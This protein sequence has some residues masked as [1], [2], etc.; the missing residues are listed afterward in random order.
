MK[1]FSPVLL[2]G[3]VCLPVYT[4]AEDATPK[5]PLTGQ[6][7]FGLEKTDG[8]TESETLNA[9]LQLIYDKDRWTHSFDGSYT[10]MQFF[11]EDNANSHML[12]E[13]TQYHLTRE[14]NYAFF[15]VWYLKD[16]FSGYDGQGSASVGYGHKLIS[17][18]KQQLTAEIGAGLAWYRERTDAANEET[19]PVGI[20]NLEYSLQLTAN[21]TLTDSLEIESGTKNT[22]V[23]NVLS[24][25]VAMN[26]KWSVNLSYN[27]MHNTDALA[28]SE[29]TDTTFS[30]SLAYNF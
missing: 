15:S 21:T 25:S 22:Y 16:K 24:L 17:S 3:L 30:T 29:K 9:A 23:A 5:S 2:A 14:V 11:G 27:V 8:N 28:G 19:Y 18:D 10:R 1:T 7:Q 12:A 4:L 26:D 20:V 13:K 6:I